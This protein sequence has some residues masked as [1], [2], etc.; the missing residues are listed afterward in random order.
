MAGVF[1]SY[2]KDDSG[3]WAGRLKDHLEMRFGA[4]QIKQDVDDIQRGAQWLEWITSEVQQADAV[5]VIIGPRWLDPANPRLQ[6]PQDV[7]RT[8][9]TLALSS[10]ALVIPVLVGGAAMPKQEDLPDPLKPLPGRQG[11]TVLDTD[12]TRGMQLLIE[13]LRQAIE[14]TRDRLPLDQLYDRLYSFHTDF[15]TRLTASDNE[16]A[17]TVAERALALLDQQQPQYPQDAQLQLSRGYF[18]KNQALA[19]QGLG[20]TIRATAAL[21]RGRRVFETMR[22]ELEIH[23]AG[24]YNGNGSVTAMQSKFPEALSWIDKALA[25][26]PNYPEAQQDRQ[27]VL[28]QMGGGTSRRKSTAP[29]RKTARR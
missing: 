2:R 6:D 19:Y 28:E 18:E 8:E 5:L 14:K 7:L 3:G 29:R 13:S 20:D 17:L 24:A 1:I 25:L 21:D 27:M 11:L 9:I 10:P 4:S 15:F 23:L 16:T 26:V 22:S 12:W